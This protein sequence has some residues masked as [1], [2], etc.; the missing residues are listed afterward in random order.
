MCKHI[1]L[2]WIV[3]VNIEQEAQ[4]FIELLG[5]Y[6]IWSKVMVDD[7]PRLNYSE[8]HILGYFIM[9]KMDNCKATLCCRC[10]G[11][12]ITLWLFLSLCG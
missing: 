11:M 12:K 5:Y 6:S 7:N 4:A 9:L 10:S 3:C 8:M 2:N 1:F